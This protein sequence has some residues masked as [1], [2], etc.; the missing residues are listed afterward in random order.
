MGERNYAVYE[1]P[2]LIKI[3]SPKEYKERLNMSDN[4]F[5]GFQKHLIENYSHELQIFG[6]IYIV[7]ADILIINDCSKDN[8]LEIIKKNIC[9]LINRIRNAYLLAKQEPN[10]DVNKQQNPKP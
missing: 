8:T 7:F 1:Q 2:Q 6:N 10:G 3:I 9:I 5:D 4:E